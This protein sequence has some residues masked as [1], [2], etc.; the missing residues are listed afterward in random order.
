MNR[1]LLA[2]VA[3]ITLLAGS[4]ALAA[5][6]VVNGAAATGDAAVTILLALKVV[7][8]QGLD[9]GAVTSGAADGTVSIDP[10]AN[11]R[12]VTGGV[13]AVAAN[14]GQPGAFLI[15]GGENA[16]IVIAIGD[17]IDGFGA[18]ITGVTRHSALLPRLQGTTQAFLVGGT[19]TIPAQ[20]PPGQYTGSYTVVVSYP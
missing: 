6:P 1:I 18:G 14:V 5:D 4:P 7:Q 12:A 10:A 2:G 16:E 3:A 17:T 20:T 11:T 15:T 9:F 13:G 8:T 19:L